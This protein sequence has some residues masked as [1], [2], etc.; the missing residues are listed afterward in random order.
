MK[1]PNPSE[2]PIMCQ[3]GKVALAAEILKSKE[4]K[5]PRSI[6]PAQRVLTNGAS[7]ERT[8][9]AGKR[10]TFHP[11]RSAPVVVERMCRYVLIAKR[12]SVGGCEVN[13]GTVSGEASNAIGM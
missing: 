3:N 1:M 11:N 2:I 9:K 6:S 5:R 4:T 13:R 7:I 12:L 8:A 10:S